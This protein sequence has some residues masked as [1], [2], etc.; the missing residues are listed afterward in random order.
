MKRL[1][2][3]RKQLLA[4]L[5]LMLAVCLFF[6]WLGAGMYRSV[7]EGDR[8]GLMPM[9]L[10]YGVFPLLVVVFSLHRIREILREVA[11]PEEAAREERM[12]TGRESLSE[13]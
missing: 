8:G 6:V 5:A 3:K 4:T 11:P 9:F 12:E 10:L 2:H 13:K 1:T 7:P